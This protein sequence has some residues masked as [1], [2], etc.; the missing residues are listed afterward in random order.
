MPVLFLIGAAAIP[1]AIGPIVLGL[2][3]VL[4]NRLR[5][6]VAAAIGAFLSPLCIVATW[7]PFRDANETLVG[8]LQF[9][10]RVPAEF[11]I[12]VLPYAIAAALFAAWIAKPVRQRRIERASSSV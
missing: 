9:W 8:L 4:G 1:L 2:R 10:A 12:G 6:A 11:V 7:L 3:W 5:P